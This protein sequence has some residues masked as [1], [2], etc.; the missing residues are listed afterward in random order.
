MN[1]Y[2]RQTSMGVYKYTMCRQLTLCSRLPCTYADGCG[3][4]SNPACVEPAFMFEIWACSCGIH[5]RLIVQEDASIQLTHPWMARAG[6][7]NKL[8]RLVASLML[9]EVASGRW[10]M[11]RSLS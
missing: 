2:L 10:Q 1:E 3:V 11:L 6:T 9:T 5:H 8:G 4:Q 7:V